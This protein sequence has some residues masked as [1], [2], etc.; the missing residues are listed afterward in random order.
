MKT[1]I[2]ALSIMFALPTLA[3]ETT[4]GFN[5]AKHYKAKKRRQFLNRVFNLNNCKHYKQHK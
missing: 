2:I 3:N 1:I 5:Y 4:K